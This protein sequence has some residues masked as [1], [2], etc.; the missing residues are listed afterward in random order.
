MEQL[1]EANRVSSRW[2]SKCISQEEQSATKISALEGTV[3]SLQDAAGASAESKKREL[4]QV[5]QQLEASFN[6][7]QLALHS[8]LSDNQHALRQL[9]SECSASKARIKEL[10]ASCA[11]LRVRKATEE[12]RLN[13]DIRR[14][15]LNAKTLQEQLSLANSKSESLLHSGEMQLRQH[16]DEKSGILAENAALREQLQKMMSMR[17]ALPGQFGSQWPSAAPELQQTAQQ[18]HSNE[19]A[20]FAHGTPSYSRRDMGANTFPASS[21]S[22]VSHSPWTH[23]SSAAA[24]THSS[25][26]AHVPSAAQ[27]SSMFTP[28]AAASAVATPLW[29]H[30]GSRGGHALGMSFASQMEATGGAGRQDESSELLKQQCVLRVALWLCSHAALTPPSD[31]PLWCRRPTA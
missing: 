7:Q 28:S 15:R 8:K 18:S 6:S 14:L 20:S 9:E 5:R 22:Q 21:A 3:K 19:S 1:Q 12:E 23:P 13:E 16:D 26:A 30:A 4:A 10:E 27:H 11:K 29:P 2:R 17:S 25:S 31:T 24:H